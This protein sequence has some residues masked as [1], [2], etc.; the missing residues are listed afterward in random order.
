MTD[1]MIRDQFQP[2]MTMA[3]A[4]ERFNAVNAFAHKVLRENVDFG[5]IPGT[6]KPTLLKPGAEKLTTFFGL[7]TR[8]ILLEKTEDWAGDQHGGEP[9][10]YYVYRC[11]LWRSDLLVA[12]SDASCNSR[13]SKYRWRNSERLCPEC[14]KATIIKG[15][16]EYGGGFVCFA[17][18]GG[19]GTKFKDTEPAILEQVLG[20]VA[21]PDIFDQINTLQKMAQK[22]ALIAVTLL[23]VNASEFFTQDVEDLE[24]PPADYSPAP[25]PAVRTID[26]PRQQPAEDA[27]LFA[28]AT[29][30]AP[31]DPNKQALIFRLKAVRDGARAMGLNLSQLNAGLVK[32]MP[33]NVLNAEIEDVRGL[34][35]EKVQDLWRE[36]GDEVPAAELAMDLDSLTDADLIALAGELK[37]RWHAAIAVA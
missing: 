26:A 34:L 19:C 11:Q 21:N 2:A 30:A 6:Q 18:K 4:V 3:D 24:M 5:I 33:S 32:S 13:E 20:R 17:K 22:R 8:F 29:P 28:E 36:L 12:E 35:I 16:A 10:F 7:T 23:A 27:P 14:G 37:Q 15:K 31:V 9:L 25:P 1:L